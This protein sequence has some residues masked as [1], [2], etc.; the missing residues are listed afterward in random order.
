MLNPEKMSRITVIG[1]KSRAYKIIDRLHKLKVYHIT[2]HVKT[3]ELDIGSP[4][5]DSEE[6]SE[7][8]VKIRA[9]S[10][11][12]NI[13]LESHRV[14]EK[15]INPASARKKIEGLSKTIDQKSSELKDAEDHI[16]ILQERLDIIE[17]L[18]ALNLNLEAF[19]DYKSLDYLFGT[20]E[21]SKEIKEELESFDG[22]CKG[23]TAGSMGRN[24]LVLFFDESIRKDIHDKISRRGFSEIDISFIAEEG[25][26]GKPSE[27]IKKLNEKIMAFEKKRIMINNELYYIKDRWEGYLADAE[28][29]LSVESEKAEAPLRFGATSEAFIIKGFVPSERADKVVKDLNDTSDSRIMIRTEEVDEHDEDIPV[30][31]NNPN[32]VGFYEWFMDLYTLPKYKEIDPTF[33]MFLTFPLFYGFMLG[34]VG[35]G[36]VTLTLFL[37]LRTRIKGDFGRLVNAMIFTSISTIIFGVLFAEYFGVE[38]YAPILVNR[39]HDTQGLMIMAVAIG[40]VHVNIGLLVGFYNELRSHG[41]VKAV[42]EK[43]SWLVLEAGVVLLALSYTDFISPRPLPWG[44]FTIIAISIFMIYRGEGAK[45]LVEIPAIFSHMLSYARLMAV[46]LASVIL[47]MV[48]NDLA[49]GMFAGGIAGI[50][51]GA[52]LL[53]VGHTINIGLGLIS[54]FLHSLR[55]H[56]VEFFTKFYDGGG[57]RYAPFGAEKQSE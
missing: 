17:D 44:G 32:P 15:K 12:L 47:A 16:R 35:Y 21:D 43:L 33:L 11:F 30:K 50:I 3:E 27:E 10:S 22:K 28:Y 49:G 45:G 18:K 13:D 19:H 57:L 29:N 23:L 20:I 14:H 4:L 2:D 54:P 55:L 37:I 42:F 52:L 7:V 51:G 48:V 25:L 41:F 38:L 34:D 56:Y 8:L 40:A 53:V 1:P 9:V 36:L 6:I 24:L 5:G 39:L 31:L 46:G 26:K